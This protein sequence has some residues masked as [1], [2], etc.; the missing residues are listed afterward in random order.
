[1][2]LSKD[3]ALR[4]VSDKHTMYR[5]AQEDMHDSREAFIDAI[6]EAKGANAT[7]EEIAA[8]CPTPDGPLSRQRIAQFLKE[9]K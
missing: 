6:V 1:M 5:H 4:V 7:Q 9:R 3:H 8:Q 2:S